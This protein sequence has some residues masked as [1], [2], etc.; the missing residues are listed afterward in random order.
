MNIEKYT[1]RARGFIQSAQSLAV[2]DGHQQFSPLHILKVLLDDSE[3]LAGGLI[4]RA[5]GNSRAILK[6]TEDALGKLPKVSGSGA[7]QVY[8]APELARAFDASEKAAEKAGDSFVTVERLLLGLT[9]EKGSEAAT[10]LSKGGVTPQ[11][12]NAAIESLRKGRTADSA[13]A[14]NAYDALKKYARDLTQAARDGKLDPVIGRDEEIRRTIQ[15]LSRRTKNNPV[16]I[17]EPGVGKTAIVEGLALRILNGDVP[18]SLKDKKLL[19]LDL[20]SLIAGA[21][22]R[23]EFEERLKAVLAEVT[24]AEGSIIL[25]ID[26]MHTLIGAGKADGAMDASNLLKPALAR[27]ELHCIGA[28]TLDEYR[29]HVEKD[30]ALARR[31]QPIFVSEPTVEDTI[32]ILRGLKDKYEQHHGVRITDSALVAATTLSNRYITDRFLPDK[33]ID[34][35][36]EASARLKMQ[37]DS[38]PEELDTMDREII[39]LKIEQ[40]ALRKES[41]AGSKSRLQTLEKELAELE[42]KSAALTARWSAEKNKLSDAQKLKSDLDALRIELANAQRRG[43]FQRAGELAYGRIPELEKKLADIEAKENPGEMMEEAVTADHIAQVVSRWTGVPVDKML[44]GEKDK[45]LKM[46]GSLGQR[47]VGQAEAVRAVATA[48]RRSRAGLQDPNRPMGSFMFLGPTGVGK[49][50]LTKALAEYLFNDETAMVRLDMSEY[51]EKHSVSRLIGA[52]PGYVGYDEGGALTEAVRR[53]PYQVVL[54]DEIEK[55]HPDVFNVL[56]QVLDDGR[57]TDGQGRTVDFRNTLII[58]TS[59]LGSEFL[60]NQPEGEDTSEVRD[61]VMGMVRAHFRPEFLNRVDEIILFHRLQKSEMGRIVEIQFA[62]L[63]KLLEERKITLTLDAAAR[64]WLAAKGWDPAYGARPLKRVIQRN[65][66]DPLAEMIL[67]GSVADG[68]RVVISSEGNV[69]TF[70][71]KAPQTAEIAT[72]EAPIPKRKLN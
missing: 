68:D 8:L 55:A 53:R 5:G 16:L 57:L 41:D 65:L 42:E 60:V 64:D 46:E 18:E 37:V 30:A 50:E 9:L 29:K 39:R 6:A 51:M 11:N 28:T 66:Q 4:D 71:G 12:L 19:V 17:G 3:G 61:Q 45:L 47:V 24:S 58:M 32:S 56:L 7:G 14:E 1:E 44:E 62:R 13:T 10:I 63:Q 67:E 34:L 25:F 69:L 21:K 70:N 38:K 20:G 52:P 54:F 72:F 59:N 33:A 2:R 48:V 40:E 31:F 49:T 15:V 36:D 43:E 35:M 26:E 27:G 22:Y 23:G